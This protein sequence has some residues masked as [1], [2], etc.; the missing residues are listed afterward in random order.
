MVSVLL[1]SKKR[2]HY[3]WNLQVTCYVSEI[4]IVII[5]NNADT[6]MAM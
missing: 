3:E 2:N 1:P 6:L 4:K 5:L